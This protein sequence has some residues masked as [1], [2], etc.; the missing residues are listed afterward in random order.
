MAEVTKLQAI[1]SMN[2]HV[3]SLL[4]VEITPEALSSIVRGT[5]FV[6]FVAAQ[7]LCP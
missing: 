7:Y 1:L 4:G 3:V 5:G 2:K 6:V